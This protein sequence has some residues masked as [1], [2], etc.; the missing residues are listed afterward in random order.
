MTKR[1]HPI[2]VL[3]DPSAAGDEILQTSAKIPG[4]TGGRVSAPM[5]LVLSKIKNA[6]AI[7]NLLPS[8][9]RF[10]GGIMS[11]AKKAW[12]VLLR[13]GYGGVKRR[14]LFVGGHRNGFVSSTIRPGL[15]LAAVDR[16]DYGEWVRRYDTLTDYGRQKLISE[17][18]TFRMKP[19]VS[20]IMPVYNPK[21]EW[22]R[23]V[24]QSVRKQIY[25]YWEL[26]IAD[27][28][29]TDKRIRPILERYA[30]EDTRIKV[31]F[32]DKNGHISA[33]SNSALALAAGEWVALV[34]QDD[35]LSEHALFW[36]VDAVNKNPD[37]L[38]IY[39]DEDK[40]DESGK[41][42]DPYF[43]CDWNMDLFYSHNM[44]SH[45]GVYRA[46]LLKEIGGFREG[47]EGSQD[48]DLALRF[49]ER[50]EAEQIVH[51]PRVLYHWRAHTH[52][53]AKSIDAKPYAV[54]AGEKALR[55][56]FQR[57]Q[58]NAVTEYDACGY[59]VRYALPDKLPLV[60]LI[61]PTRNGWRLLQRCVES[62]L[63][64][65]LIPTMRS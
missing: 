54:I 35:L 52:S 34:D 57:M 24:I 37:A 13:E 48:Y 14:I 50:S 64:K 31:M 17:M 10:G 63:E 56:H 46:G 22:L 55:E 26:C 62:I 23:E 6:I 65:P 30:S 58:I 44:I 8:M 51:I 27:D 20:I 60:S 38:L 15:T 39:S 3:N 33:A 19:F 12:R 4:S 1:N 28:A 2:R 53:A 5:R 43:K 11:S 21:P 45:L 9:I 16:N 42:Y 29:S 25:P 7:F 32:R 49:V 59:R 36:V 40:I 47:L 18:F 41:R 61:I